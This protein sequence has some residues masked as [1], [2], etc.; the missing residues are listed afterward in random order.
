[1]ASYLERGLLQLRTSFLPRILSLTSRFQTFQALANPAYARLWGANWLLYIA[2]MI[3][4]MALSWL[5]LE[6]TD[7]PARVAFVG[8]SRMLPMFFLGLVAGSLADR[9]SKVGALVGVQAL[10][11]VVGCSVMALL[12]SG[13]IE[14]WHTYLAIFLTGTGWTLDFAARRSYYSELFDPGGLVNA[15]SLDTASLMGSMMLG[16]LLGGSL[17]ALVGFSGTY[18]VMV[19]MYLGGLVLILSLVKYGVTR[20]SAPKGSIVSQV[21]EAIQVVRGNRSIWAVFLVTVALNFFGFPYLQMVPV[22]ARD[23]LGVREVLFGILMSAAGMGALVGSLLIASSRVSRQG[24]VY[25]LGACLMLAALLLFALSQV[26]IISIVLLFVAGLGTSGFA[27]MQVTIALRAVSPEMRGRAMGAVA[28]G[29]GASPLGMMVVGPLAE[30]LNTQ[31]ALALL[32]GSGLLVMTIMYWRLP[33]LRDR[34]S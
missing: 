9:L 3:E 4:L 21:T 30:V 29:I 23:V 22:I 33:E 11:M 26:Y 1:M 13:N 2:R 20:N 34:A 31:V 32:T 28:L 25:S 18:A 8:V 14:V 27:T 15:V 7:S 12:I 6:L 16:P 17:I 10:N 19:A 5:V 24:T